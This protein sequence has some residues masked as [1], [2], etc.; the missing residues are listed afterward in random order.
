MAM[1]F[2]RGVGLPGRV[3][4]TKAAT[5]IADLQQ[6]G[7][8]PRLQLAA[9]H[10]LRSAFAFPIMLGQQVYGVMEF[11]AEAVR[12][13]DNE[14]LQMSG[15]LGYQIGEFLERTRAQQQL[16]EREESYRVLAE[17]AS[18]GIITIDATSTILFANTAA[19]RI[20]GYCD[21]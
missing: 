10:G 3:W 6:D 11:L 12:A 8:F 15:S 20:F 5:W 4:S 13:A 9:E 19:A 17:T 16:A 2:L 21:Q 1:E 7:N 18:D 14:L